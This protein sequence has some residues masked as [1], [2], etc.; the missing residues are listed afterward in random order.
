MAPSESTSMP[1]E[2][3]PKGVPNPIGTPELD[4]FMSRVEA[5][6]SGCW[7]WRGAIGSSRGYG[8]F[9]GIPNLAHRWSYMT[10]VGP[11]PEGLQIDHLC[12]NRKCV[13]PLH[14]EPVTP[15]ENVRRGNVGVFERSKTHCPKGHEYSPENTRRDKR[16]KR[17]CMT[18]NRIKGRHWRQIYKSRASGV[19]QDVS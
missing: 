18:C 17:Y 2:Y 8:L 16:G 5:V 9:K 13:N 11:I 6:E 4:R 15:G 7:E 3:L 19:L 12:R 14:L 10:M 1:N